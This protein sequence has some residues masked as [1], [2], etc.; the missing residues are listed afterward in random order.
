MA[1]RARTQDACLRGAS[2]PFCWEDW[3]RDMDARYD[4]VRQS[5]AE[6]ERLSA[7]IAEAHR[8]MVQDVTDMLAG[9]GL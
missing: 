6:Y 3:N 4:A 9:E 2:K 5:I 8:S 7:E 1:S